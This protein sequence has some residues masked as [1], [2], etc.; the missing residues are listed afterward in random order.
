MEINLKNKKE[1]WPILKCFLMEDTILLHL[2][3]TMVQ[4]FLKLIEKLLK[5]QKK[6]RLKITLKQ[7]LQR[8]PIS[9]AEVNVGN[10]SENLLNEIRQIMYSL[11]QSKE[12]TKKSIQQYN[13]FNRSIMQKRTLCF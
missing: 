12:I 5:N 6:K 3:M 4:L 9:L 10:I 7:M 2:Q 8:L 1:H 11:C 13:E